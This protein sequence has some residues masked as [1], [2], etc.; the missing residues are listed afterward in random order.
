MSTSHLDGAP[1]RTPGAQT[2]ANRTLGVV[3]MQLINK[4]TYIW[5]PLI[6]L[7]G[8]F[9]LALAIYVILANSGVPGPFYGGGA[10]AP[11]W[12][13]GIVGIQALTLT[14]P[15][16]QAMS[17]SRREFYLGTLLTAALTSAILAAIAVVGGLIERATNGWGVNGWFFGLPWIWEN[18]PLGAFLVNFVLA[19]LFFVVGFWC[20]TIY[21]RFGSIW[22][23][24]VLVGV[25]A[26]FV[27]GLWAIGRLDAWGVVGEWIA[28]QGVTGLSLWGLVLAVVLAGSAFLTLRRAVP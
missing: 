2:H 16:S 11:L 10:Q 25:G 1:P 18:G 19:M 13:F 7:G 14:F 9:F 12:Y 28:T 4:Q 15:F 6:I 27:L 3:R 5:I 23:T 20:A 8:A 26:L 21:K 24:A 17:V 22:L